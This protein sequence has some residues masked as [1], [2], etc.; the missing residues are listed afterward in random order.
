MH[1]ASLRGV[2]NDVVLRR[3]ARLLANATGSAATW[4]L[5]TPVDHLDAFISHNWCVSRRRQWLALC[6]QYHLLVAVVG[7]FLTAAVL[8]C[9]TT[10]GILHLSPV[11]ARREREGVYCGVLGFLTFHTLLL[12]GADVLP[13]GCLWPSKV[14]LDK[15]CIHQV[16]ENLKRQGIESLGSFLCFSWSF[17]VLYTRDYTQRVWTVYEMACFLCF[18]PEGRLVWLPVN[19]PPLVLVGIHHIVAR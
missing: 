13:R 1:R 14:F 12:F 7:S 9:M 3:R 16:D 10:L 5:S 19:L 8:A 17:V 6:L 2:G 15:A 4:A 18:H 11:D